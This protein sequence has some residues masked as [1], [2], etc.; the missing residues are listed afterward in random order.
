[1]ARFDIVEALVVLAGKLQARRVARL[2][3]K[4]AALVA[5]IQFAAKALTETQRQRQTEQKHK[6][7]AVE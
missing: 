2:K 3:A 5:T 4:E 1:M 6:L 7:L